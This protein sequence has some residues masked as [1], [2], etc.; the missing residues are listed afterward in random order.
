MTI[1]GQGRQPLDRLFIVAFSLFATTSMILEQWIVFGVDLSTATD[2]LGRVWCW[3]AQS[4]DPLLLDRLLSIRVMFGIDAWVIGPFY[5]VLIYAIVH[6]RNWIR[7]PALMYVALML[8]Q[9]L[10]YTLMTLLSEHAPQ[11]NLPVILLVTAPYTIVP[12]L[13]A[14]RMRHADP[15]GAP[16][17]SQSRRTPLA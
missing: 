9:N 13:L 16:S 12:L 14:Y 1:A 4:F 7:L 17:A 2:P 8:Y 10:V 15:F 3:Y 6:R 11:S 5:V